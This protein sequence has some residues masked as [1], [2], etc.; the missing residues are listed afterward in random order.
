MTMLPA[1]S[2]W[3]LLPNKG[4]G[5]VGRHQRQEGVVDKRSP[6]IKVMPGTLVLDIGD[7]V[8]LFLKDILKSPG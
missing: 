7:F 8:A 4:S 2:N 3:T 5:T 6:V 1:A